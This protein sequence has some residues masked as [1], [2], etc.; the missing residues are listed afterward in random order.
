MKRE[1][2]KPI[3][4]RVGAS[5]VMP[6]SKKFGEVRGFLDGAMSTIRGEVDG[7]AEAM[8]DSLFAIGDQ[9]VRDGHLFLCVKEAWHSISCHEGQVI[10]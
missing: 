2:I 6:F 7:Y 4:I 10:L 3:K 8:A 5:I 9:F 1:S